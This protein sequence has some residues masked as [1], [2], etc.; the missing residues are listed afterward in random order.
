MKEI[1]KHGIDEFYRALSSDHPECILVY[2]RCFVRSRC[3]SRKRLANPI[4]K[5]TGKPLAPATIKR[6]RSELRYDERL[7]RDYKCAI[8]LLVAYGV[9][10]NC[11]C[12]QEGVITPEKAVRQLE[13][14]VEGWRQA[15]RH[16]HTMFE[17]YRE[18]CEELK[19]E[20]NDLLEQ[21]GYEG[22]AHGEPSHTKTI[23]R[24]I[25]GGKRS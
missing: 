2:Y 12:E 25:P 13:S 24:L 10:G 23:L 14:E 4:N 8:K 7:V 19:T 5:R 20:R 18:F 6:Y 21:L 11:K 9:L 1:T 17:I 15:A 22:E 16:W 3:E